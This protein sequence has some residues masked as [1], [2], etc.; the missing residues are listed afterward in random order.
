MDERLWPIFNQV[1]TTHCALGM[2]ATPLEGE[3]AE[4]YFEANDKLLELITLR[5]QQGADLP[6][7]LDGLAAL[8]RTLGYEVPLY[9]ELT[10][11]EFFAHFRA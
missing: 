7:S 5:N 8:F 11:E 10:P 1:W 4:K 6:T 2:S 3:P 9:Q